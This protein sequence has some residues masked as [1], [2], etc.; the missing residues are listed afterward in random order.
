MHDV[1]RFDVVL[2][3]FNQT[4][5]IREGLKKYSEPH[6]KERRCAQARNLLSFLVGPL[7]RAEFIEGL[8][9]AEW[10]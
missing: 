10:L 6:R 5:G 9:L 1:G 3:P 2:R 8:K 7:M 4:K